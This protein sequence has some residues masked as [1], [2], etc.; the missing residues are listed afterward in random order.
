MGVFDKAKRHGIESA[1]YA[2]GGDALKQIA[3]EWREEHQI[4]W[5]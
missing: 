4:P 5:K 2:F 1:W 3:I